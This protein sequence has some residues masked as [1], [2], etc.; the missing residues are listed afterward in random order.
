MEAI[1][2]ILL[3]ATLISVLDRYF[4][5]R[6]LERIPDIADFLADPK[7]IPADQSIYLP[8]PNRPL[9]VLALFGLAYPLSILVG[10]LVSVGP[11]GFFLDL[12]NIQGRQKDLIEQIGFVVVYLPGH[13]FFSRMFLGTLWFPTMELTRDELIC[14]MGKA[15]VRIPW[16]ILNT[17]PCEPWL[18]KNKNL[19]RFAP[20]PIYSPARSIVFEI[21]GKPREP[22]APELFPVKLTGGTM[23]G[24]ENYFAVESL[25]LAKFLAGV[26]AIQ[27]TAGHGLTFPRPGS[28]GLLTGSISA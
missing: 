23:V 8:A 16:V 2:L 21:D 1:H 6:R 27:V 15:C 25:Q 3:L 20:V 18:D 17:L 22:W 5:Q 28:Q 9:A 19:V 14:R 10:T 13:Y 24:F 7:P 11:V 26:A 4:F 12:I